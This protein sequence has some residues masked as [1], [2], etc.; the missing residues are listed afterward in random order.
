MNKPD[1]YQCRYRGSIPGDAHSK[2]NYP[3]NK[4]GILD[5]F[6]PENIMNAGRLHIQAQQHAVEKGWFMWPVN[7]DPTW[8][9]NC[10][11]FE[12]KD[13]PQKVITLWQPWAMLAVL[14]EK[15]F[16]TRP[17]GITWHRYRGRL[18][19]HSSVS[20]PKEAKELC[21]TE[22]F[23]SVLAKHGYTAENLPLG[24]ILGSVRMC[25]SEIMT[26]K[27]IDQVKLCYENEI[28][29]GHYELGRRAIW[30]KDA[31]KFDK[32]IKARGQQGM[33]NYPKVS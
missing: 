13:T 1:C 9:L 18:L 22:P 5:F 14:G 25:H 26:R 27:F 31:V 10:D 28:H 21:D 15:V 4:T 16:E 12:D 6:M 30:L 23:R 3:G 29:F 11:G 20:F 7:F 17:E 32:F 33:W 19:I 8:L 2:C 24:Q